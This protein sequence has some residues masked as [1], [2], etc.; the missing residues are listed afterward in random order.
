MTTKKLV[1]DFR[2]GDNTNPV[3]QQVY[4]Y[5]TKSNRSVTV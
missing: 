2:L 3:M 1:L 4:N 5:V